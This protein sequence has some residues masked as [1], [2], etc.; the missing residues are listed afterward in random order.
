MYTTDCVS[1]LLCCVQC[2]GGGEGLSG[3]ANTIV[4]MASSQKSMKLEFFIS[5]K[6]FNILQQFG[7][8]LTWF[9]YIV[10]QKLAMCICTEFVFSPNCSKITEVSFCTI[11]FLQILMLFKAMI[12]P[13]DGSY[14]Q[15]CPSRIHWDCRKSFDL[16]E[17]STYK[18][19]KTIEYKERGACIGLWLGQLFDLLWIQLRQ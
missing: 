19:V 8:N 16:R 3:C 4:T 10:T 1:L 17:N 7:Q 5:N 11:F 15:L 14:S 2:R 13:S 18:G 6:E 12:T 9:G